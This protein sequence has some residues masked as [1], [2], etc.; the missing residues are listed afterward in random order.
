MFNKGLYKLLP[1]ETSVR[2]SY[3]FRIHEARYVFIERIVKSLVDAGHSVNNISLETKQSDPA[4]FRIRLK[5][6][7]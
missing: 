3:L 6:R 5:A 1:T 4:Y 7:G 2:T